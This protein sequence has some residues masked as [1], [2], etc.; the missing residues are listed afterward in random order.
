[1]TEKRRGRPPKPKAPLTFEQINSGSGDTLGVESSTTDT[2]EFINHESLESNQISQETVKKGETV[3]DKTNQGTTDIG[4][5]EEKLSKNTLAAASKTTPINTQTPL[6]HIHLID[7]EK[8]G[9]GKS[10]FARTL[11]HYLSVK[12][13]S[14]FVLID[15]DNTNPDVS[16][17]YGGERINFSENEL[18]AY[19]ADRII[20]LA[21]NQSVIVNLPAQIYPIVKDWIINN[22][23]IALGQTPEANIRLIKWF[24]CTGAVD[25][26]KLFEESYKDFGEK[27]T[28]VL[29]KNYSFSQD[30]DAISINVDGKFR[31]VKFP[32]L[33]PLER[34]TVVSG[35]LSFATALESPELKILG[36]QRLRNFL[37]EAIASLDSVKD[38][39]FLGAN[40]DPTASY[41]GVKDV[42][43][44]SPTETF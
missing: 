34:D 1:M 19:A 23:L 20:E 41:E 28:H 26:V 25:S 21:L 17:V 4:E 12:K 30:W 33:T 3:G 42:V 18:K 27:I 32:K 5:K 2:K 44:E 14:D 22:D 43:I 7:G 24:V 40:L 6:T 10:F 35:S 11:L 36:R 16:E 9:V 39:F 29:V 13:I 8:G 37:L 15:A 38:L 31:E